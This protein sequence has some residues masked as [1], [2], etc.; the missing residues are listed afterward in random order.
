M[1]EAVL[2]YSFFKKIAAMLQPPSLIILYIVN[3]QTNLYIS[4]G[5]CC[6]NNIPR[7]KLG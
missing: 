5:S 3:N 1:W 4:I 2:S 6:T 7:Y